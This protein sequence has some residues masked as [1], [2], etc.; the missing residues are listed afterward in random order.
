[1]INYFQTHSKLLQ[2]V[3]NVTSVIEN[4]YPSEKISEVYCN[5]TGK[6]GVRQVNY[7]PTMV[8]LAAAAIPAITTIIIL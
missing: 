1:M 8:M 4:N 3:P 2:M 5:V 6:T 7:T